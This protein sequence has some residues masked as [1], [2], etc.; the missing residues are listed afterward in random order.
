MAGKY[1][2]ELEP[3]Q[4]I[5]H[6]LGKTI[7]EA[8]HI[9]FCAMTMN[10]QPLHINED[11]ASR[12][13]YGQRLVNG[14]LTMSLVVGIS[15]ADTTEGTIIANLGYENVRHPRPV[16]HGDTI[17]AETTVVAKRESRSRPNTGIVTLTHVGH[18]QRGEI[19]VEVT[20]SA[21]FLKRPD[22]AP[23]NGS[24]AITDGTSAS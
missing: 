10:Q 11:F 9:L 14:L 8:E 23:G 20:R 15:V 5:R 1:Y 3:G 12:T 4:V 19:V 7:T 2:D 6:A 22:G 21:L 17:Y 24:D 16:F 18:N 13:E